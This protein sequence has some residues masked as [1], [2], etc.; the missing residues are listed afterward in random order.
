MTVEITPGLWAPLPS[1]SPSANPSLPPEHLYR[2]G[3]QHRCLPR[4]P[5]GTQSGQV[6]EAHGASPIL[7][8]KKGP[9]RLGWTQEGFG[10]D[11]ELDPG[12]RR[13]ER[14]AQAGLEYGD[15]LGQGKSCSGEWRA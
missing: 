5:K 7:K 11:V 2:T 12:R 1:R 15:V 13:W 6:Q 3:S 14:I 4:S 9:E 10:G 8:V